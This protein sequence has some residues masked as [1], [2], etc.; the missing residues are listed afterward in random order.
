MSFKFQIRS[1]KPPFYPMKIKLPAMLQSFKINLRINLILILVFTGFSIAQGQAPGAP[2]NLVVTPI[3]SGGMIQFM[4]PSSAGGSAITNYEY[5]TDNGAT[6]VTPNP[7][8][9]QSPLIISSGLTNCT[10]YQIKLRAVNASGSGT[11]SAV[12][13]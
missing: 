3:N 10:T 1:T 9:T 5:S 6:W 2:T 4:A 12:V 8:V 13:N 7:A 11:P